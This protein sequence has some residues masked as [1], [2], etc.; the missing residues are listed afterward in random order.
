LIPAK[1]DSLPHAHAQT[2]KTYYKHQDSSIKKAQVL[3]TKTFVNF[4]IKDNSSE[5]KLH[6]RLLESFQDDA[7]YEHVG[8]DTRSQ[9]GK[10]DKDIQGKD[11]KDLRRDE[12]PICT[13]GDYSKPS[14]EGYRN[15]FEL[16]VGNNVTVKAITLPQDVPSTSDRC[17]IE[18][19]NEVQRLMEAHLSL[20]Q[21]TQVN[22]ITTSCKICS[23]PHDTQ[24]YMKDPEQ[25]FVEYASLRTDEAG[26]YFP[27]LSTRSYA[28]K[29]PQCSTHV[30]GLI[31]AVTIHPKK[32][33]DSHDDKT[34]K[35][36]E[37]EKDDPENIHIN[38]S[39]PPDP[40]VLFIT[41]KVLKLNS[42]FESLKLVPQSSNT[43]L[44]CT[45]GD[46]DDVMFIKIVQMNDDSHKEEP[47]A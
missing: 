32:Q 35:N 24:Y 6:G 26:E 1:S 36:E 16:P 39:T 45:K 42:F 4:D 38:P 44:V 41:E 46:D 47:E 33:S 19:K 37:E 15:T 30:H 29:D 21:V 11:F 25:A 31:N 14:Y 10:D 12:N 34:R 28:T 17:L 3:K 23:G 43:E 8:D 5:T 18:L 2:T 20:M 13:L 22:K 40:F 9:Y 27:V 7:K